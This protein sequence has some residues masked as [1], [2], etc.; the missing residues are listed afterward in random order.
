M[1]DDTDVDNSAFIAELD[2]IDAQIR[3]WERERRKVM[4]RAAGVSAG[5]MVMAQKHK[6]G[7][8]YAIVT[9]VG[10]RLFRNARPALKGRLNFNGRWTE[11]AFSLDTRWRPL[12]PAEREAAPISDKDFAKG[13]A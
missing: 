7:D 2:K 12:T 4:W 10:D 13:A 1:S 5:E 9:D 8:K 6:F 11:R 3:A